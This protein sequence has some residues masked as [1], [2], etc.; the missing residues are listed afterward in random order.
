[1][2]P[3]AGSTAH[4][5]GEGMQQ[6]RLAEWVR[7]QGERSTG[8]QPVSS[9]NPLIK[10]WNPGRGVVLTTLRVGLPSHFEQGRLHCYI[11][12]LV[13]I[14]PSSS[15]MSVFQSWLCRIILLMCCL[16][17]CLTAPSLLPD[18]LSLLMIC[19]LLSASHN[20]LS[21]VSISLEI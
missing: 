13:N 20:S 8:A 3:S 14:A 18:A 9:P 16:D 4:A 19:V 11:V 12:C 17:L 6:E 7:K 5:V 2:A 1:M 10:S 15:S 21:Y